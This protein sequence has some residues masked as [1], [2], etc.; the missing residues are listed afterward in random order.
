[1]KPLRTAIIGCGHFAHRHAQILT[2]LEQVRLVGFCNR[3]LAKA[4]AFNQQYADGQAQVYGDYLPP[5][6]HGR[7]VTLACQHGVHF[8]IE[9]PIALTMDVA[10]SM[11]ECVQE[12]GVKS[13]VGFMF[14]Y[15]EAVQQLKAYMSGAGV[16]RKGLFVA[17]YFCNSL[18]SEWWRDRSRS[19]GQIVEQI[20][21]MFDLARFLFGEPIHVYSMQE[22]LFHTDV[23]DYTVEDASG[24][25]ARFGS[26]SLA[27]FV[28]SNGAIPNRWDYDL[29]VIAP[30]LT[31][32]LEDAN[33]AVF[34][35]TDREWGATTT[36]ASEKDI[37]LAET[38]DLL[39]AIRE[40]RP[41]A[42][43]IEEGVRSLQFVLAAARSAELDAPVGVP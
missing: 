2:H 27:V 39:E 31:A 43:P 38:L 32:D 6:A 37:Y 24:T 34:H 20:I 25:I 22:N 19:G 28:A 23:V 4:V 35:H 29:Q 1:M 11:A 16:A 17:R 21:H 13:Q 9:K 14:R 8:M 5:Y 18:H 26:G 3:T 36:I 33:H 15:G 30:G 12:S 7:E 40:D 41:T 10:R 42:V